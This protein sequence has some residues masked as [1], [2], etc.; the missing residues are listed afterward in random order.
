MYSGDQTGLITKKKKNKKNKNQLISPTE[1]LP[2][3]SFAASLRSTSAVVA[4][5]AVG[6]RGNLGFIKNSRGSGLKES[7]IPSG[8]SG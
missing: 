3:G 8:T 5:V 7:G 6:A 4:L 2:S 1:A